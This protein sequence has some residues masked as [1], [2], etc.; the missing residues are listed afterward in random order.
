MS[1][2]LVHFLSIVGEASQDVETACNELLGRRVARSPKSFGSDDW[3][4]RDHKDI[5]K[6]CLH[7]LDTA[8][9]LPVLH[10]AQYLDAW[11]V[12]DSRFSLLEWP[13]D[14]R[15]Q[16]CGAGYGIAFYP[17]GHCESVLAQI[18]KKRRTKLYRTW[19]EDRWYLDHLKDAIEAALWLEAPYLVVS[20]SQCLGPSREDGEIKAGL[21]L[22]IG[23][24]TSSPRQLE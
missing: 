7:L 22:P 10:Y 24:G 15:R 18:K 3:S 19:T 17:G 21:D 16:I 23:R 5:E 11:T 12:A 14:R 20:I 13:D 6:F 4:R 1:T 2:S 8:L 9:N